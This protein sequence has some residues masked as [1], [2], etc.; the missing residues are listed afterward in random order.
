MTKRKSS[1]DDIEDDDDV[2][3]DN[4]ETKLASSAAS[5][6][7]VKNIEQSFDIGDKRKVTISEFKGKLFINIR[8]YYE[9]KST[10]E[11]KPGILEYEDL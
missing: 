2:L 10:G 11:L 7:K 5:K 3:D 4:E 6:K 1:N 8:E 9:D